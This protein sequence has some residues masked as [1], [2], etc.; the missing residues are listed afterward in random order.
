M[1]KTKETLIITKTGQARGL[2][3]P[4]VGKITKQLGQ[5]TIRRASHVEV[6]DDLTENAKRV[7]YHDHVA[8]AGLPVHQ[9]LSQLP[10][11]AFWADMS[12]CHAVGLVLGPFD[13]REDALAAEEAWLIANGIPTADQP[14]GN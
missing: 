5:Q 10:T 8:G 2:L 13:T 9:F 11:N 7:L 6:T 1:T 14:L 12:P 3:G 4:L